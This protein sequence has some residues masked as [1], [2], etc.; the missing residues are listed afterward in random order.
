MTVERKMAGILMQKFNHHGDSKYHENLPY[1]L[2]LLRIGEGDISILYLIYLFYHSLFI[3]SY[4]MQFIIYV[5][6]N[7]QWLITAIFKDRNWEVQAGS[8]DKIFDKKCLYV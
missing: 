5:N 7:I 1:W 3:S 2:N 6:K 4:Q 8:L